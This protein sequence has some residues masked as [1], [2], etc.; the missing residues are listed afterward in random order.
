M[1]DLH[2]GVKILKP[3]PSSDKTMMVLR[4]VFIQSKPM[5]GSG[6]NKDRPISR[7]QASFSSCCNVW[8]ALGV[9]K[10]GARFLRFN[11]E[12]SNCVFKRRNMSEICADLACRTVA[13]ACLPE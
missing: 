1:T 11:V 6:S 9:V 12:T 2:E 8:G 4:M 10:G 3:P 7:A 5:K 13:D